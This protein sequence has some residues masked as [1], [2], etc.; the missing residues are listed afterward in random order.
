[1]PFN[2]APNQD[3]LVQTYNLPAGSL[4]STAFLTWD[5]FGG[6]VYFADQGLI[7]STLYRLPQ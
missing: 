2:E 4:R 6:S 3:D 1:M 7:T 5:F